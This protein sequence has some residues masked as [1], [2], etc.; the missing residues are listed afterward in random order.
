MSGGDVW[1]KRLAELEQRSFK[2]YKARLEAC[3]RL[4][5]RA[6]ALNGMVVALSLAALI[7]ASGMVRDRDLYGPNGDVLWL[8]IAIFTFAGSLASS[9]IGYGARSRNMFQS[10]RRIQRLSV[11]A[12]TAKYDDIQHTEAIFTQLASEY[13]DLLDES[14]N[15]TSAD[16][17]RARRQFSPDAKVTRREHIQML[18]SATLTWAPWLGT[19]IPLV[20]VIPAFLT[21]G[22]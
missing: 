9:S 7:A 19:V 17:L 5:M 14:E 21:F 8:F 22:P 1:A 6:R 10:Y 15:H 3:K 12:E 18:A 2:T 20:L 16:Y 4:E 13:D 11:K